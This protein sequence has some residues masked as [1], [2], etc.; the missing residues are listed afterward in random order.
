MYGYKTDLPH[1]PSFSFSLCSPP[2]TDTHP[3][4]RFRSMMF[5]MIDLRWAHR[6]V[7]DYQ[8]RPNKCWLPSF[9]SWCIFSWCIFSWDL[10]SWLVF[11]GEI[12]KRRHCVS[13]STKTPLWKSSFWE[14]SEEVSGKEGE[15]FFHQ[16]AS[17]DHWNSHPSPTSDPSS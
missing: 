5:Y 3:Q 10:T 7:P 15:S 14:N 17:I 11:S 12:P 4:K 9:I 6:T 16:M 1:I 13:S 8:C 2:P